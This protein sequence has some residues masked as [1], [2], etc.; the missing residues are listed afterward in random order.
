ME[1]V[2]SQ[3]FSASFVEGSAH[4]LAGDGEARKGCFTP[5]KVKP[6]VPDGGLSFDFI[7]CDYCQIANAFCLL[8]KHHQ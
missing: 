2:R 4:I 6:V 8:E 3:S 5:E 7:A 1:L